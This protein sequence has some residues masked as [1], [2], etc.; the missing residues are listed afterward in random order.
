MQEITATETSL[1]K[2]ICGILLGVAILNFAAFFIMAIC[3]GGDAINGMVKDGHYYLAEH[4]RYT[5]VT[6]AVFNYSRHHAYSVF[7]THPIGMVAAWYLGRITSPK[8][9]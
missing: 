1:A 8:K 4:G 3:L 5:E 7:V 9:A 2:A 6:E